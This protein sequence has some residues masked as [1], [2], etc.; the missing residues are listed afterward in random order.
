MNFVN[1]TT[2][3]IVYLDDNKVFV[4]GALNVISKID[5]KT[6]RYSR[7]KFGNPTVDAK[8]MNGTLTFDGKTYISSGPPVN[9]Q[10]SNNVAFKE[11]IV[12]TGLTLKVDNNFNNIVYRDITYP[13]LSIKKTGIH[14]VYKYEVGDLA[15]SSNELQRPHTWNSVQI[16]EKRT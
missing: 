1:G 9:E 15:I 10:E 12:T 13:I 16:T 11:Y 3:V 8:I 2:N 5:I 14:T 4:N 7:F 6:D